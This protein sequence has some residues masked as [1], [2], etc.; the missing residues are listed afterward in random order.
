MAR[1]TL[2]RLG[3]RGG[4]RS[5]E[6]GRDEEERLNEEEREEARAAEDQDEEERELEEDERERE[7]EEE[8]EREL[9]ES[10]EEERAARRG[11]QAERR[12]IAGI[13]RSK[14]ACGRMETALALA[15]DTSMSSAQASRVLAAVPK[16]SSRKG[17]AG[18]AERMAAESN[19][20]V[21]PGGRSRAA[22]DGWDRAIRSV[23]QA[24]GFGR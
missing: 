5:E 2:G 8:E 21:G 24:H 7:L 15:L 9:E 12:R 6:P 10:E 4:R 1:S 18:L 22:T 11:A 19:P 17:S 14:A 23:N 16:E 13:L 20:R 3:L